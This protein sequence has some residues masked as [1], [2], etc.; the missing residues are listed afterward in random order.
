[1][2]FSFQQCHESAARASKAAVGGGNF[3]DVEMVI[4]ITTTTEAADALNIGRQI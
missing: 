1:L 4:S 3:D 2:K